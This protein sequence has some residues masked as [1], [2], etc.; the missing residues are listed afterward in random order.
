MQRFETWNMP[1]VLCQIYT[2]AKLVP[3]GMRLI[4]LMFLY[5]ST[6]G[7]NLCMVRQRNKF[8]I[9]YQK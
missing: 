6:I 5:P 8:L 9:M 1:S 3:K 2:V 7:P 4:Y